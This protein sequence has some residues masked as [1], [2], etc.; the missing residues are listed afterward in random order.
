MF[1]NINKSLINLSKI[2]H[3]ND[4]TVNTT[5]ALEHIRSLMFKE[6]TDS[7]SDGNVY[8]DS[9]NKLHMV[10]EKNGNVRDFLET[11]LCGVLSNVVSNTVYSGSFKSNLEK[12]GVIL[13]DKFIHD[14]EKK[15]FK[16]FEIYKT[17]KLEL[18]L[19]SLVSNICNGENKNS[20]IEQ[21]NSSISNTNIDP[22][23]KEVLKSK[24]IHSSNMAYYS[25]LAEN[26]PVELIGDFKYDSSI[27]LDDISFIK[28]KA[29]HH[30]LEKKKEIKKNLDKI[31]NFMTDGTISEYYYNQLSDKAKISID[32]VLD[33]KRFKILCYLNPS[34]SAQ[35]LALLDN[36]SY[37]FYEK[38]AILDNTKKEVLLDPV[39]SFLNFS[40][41]MNIPY[42][43]SNLIFFQKNLGFESTRI[44]TNK[45][46]K[47][48]AINLSKIV[49]N[50]ETNLASF[51]AVFT[52]SKSPNYI[53][54]VLGDDY[55]NETGMH[56]K[57]I[58]TLLQNNAIYES[59]ILRSSLSIE[60]EVFRKKLP[61]KDFALIDKALDKQLNDFYA[62]MYVFKDG[63]MQSHVSN[64]I[65]SARDYA[66]YLRFNDKIDIDE[67]CK[68]SIKKIIDPLY[69]KYKKTYYPKKA[70]NKDDA[71]IDID[72]KVLNQKIEK[73]IPK[74]LNEIYDRYKT[75][76]KEKN[77]IID[78][79][80]KIKKSS[81]AR[82]I[83]PY[84]TDKR[85][86]FTYKLDKEDLPVYSA[87]GKLFYINYD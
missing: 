25:F 38:Q 74:V 86:Y 31:F 51:I 29:N 41:L 1:E 46:R 49:F 11:K 6:Y 55:F 68:T 69:T 45:D 82:T 56:A 33:L 79:I 84:F 37:N 2:G 22:G 27:S 65:Y 78:F 62:S 61:K 35:K 42:S 80:F 52:A 76:S 81:F 14:F 16:N 85:I 34:E 4:F 13:K 75:E 3:E 50:D 64:L 63:F 48:D 54:E 53:E 77:F 18:A 58:I 73:E 5:I 9:E 87:D 44:L 43:D 17:K 21:I 47:K 57:T 8:E 71:L 15:S 10:S 39:S 32:E 72:A 83:H 28:N 12:Q 70:Y 36:S 66:A 24:Y 26:N 40:T 23:S 67:C 20:I 7:I 60:N 30:I 59:E 19:N